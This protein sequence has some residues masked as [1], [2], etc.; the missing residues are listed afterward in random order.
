MSVEEDI[1]VELRA[2]TPWLRLLGLQALRPVLNQ[3]LRSDRHKLVF[4]ASDGTRTTRQ[5][6]D[7][8]GVGAATVSRLWN[9]WLALGICTPVSGHAGRARHLAS[10]SSLG[11]DFPGT[12]DKPE[13]EA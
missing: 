7:A 9:E 5:V 12:A 3:A 4:E 10:L 11:I 8:A 13:Q 1:L 2:Q 6:A